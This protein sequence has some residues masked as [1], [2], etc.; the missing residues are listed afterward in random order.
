MTTEIEK[1]AAKR[2]ATLPG[3]WKTRLLQSWNEE[4]KQGGDYAA[5]ADRINAANVVLH[6]I[7]EELTG[8]RLPLDVTDAEICAVAELLA[9]RSFE[10]A[11]IYHHPEDLRAALG[12][13]AENHGIT[14]PD[15]RFAD[16]PAIA[17]LSDPMWWRRQLRRAHGRAVE[18]AAIAIGL[19]N[20]QRE[21]YASNETVNRRAAQVQRNL[22]TL[23][24]T[25]AVNELGQEYTLAE[26]AAKGT[27]NKAIRRT[28]LM[29]RIGG[30][31]RIAVDMQH[32]GLF[33]TLTAPSR[34]HKFTTVGGKVTENRKYDGTLPNEAQK[35]HVKNWAL[36][37]AALAR[38]ELRVYGFRVVEPNHDETPH[39]HLLLFFSPHW[40]GWTERAAYPRVCAIV[41]RYCLRDNAAKRERGV[42]VRQHRCDFKRMEPAQGQAGAYIAKYIAKNI[43]GYR[44]EKDLYGNDSIAASQRIEA[45][46][47][48]WGIRQFQQVGGPPV[49]VWRELRRVESVPENAPEAM[50]AAHRAA[51]KF[52]D[53]ETG[54]VKSVSWAR[55]VK[56]QGGPHCGRKYK[57]R[58]SKTNV[59]DDGLNRY[60][61]PSAP[62][63]IGI[64]MTEKESYLPA[65]M[66]HLAAV[67]ASADRWV[68]WQVDSARHRWEIRPKGG[69]RVSGALRPW[70]CVN[71][72]TQGPDL[73][74]KA[75]SENMAEVEH[76]LRLARADEDRVNA[77]W[78]EL[79]G[80]SRNLEKWSL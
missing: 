73:V 5:K 70:P 21:C 77:M 76:G 20:K 17:R 50:R 6:R 54:E 26:L 10:L 80:Q 51:N 3:R 8:Q 66:A 13:I 25:T 47:T 75:A 23:E 7:T 65:H 11:T 29:T 79:A 68:L 61:E 72:C 32:A 71:N 27:S 34:M 59:G 31:E 64:E 49:T 22:E 15:C 44:L 43:D 2:V 1:W 46:A 4:R 38:R 60:G 52:A 40:P 67:G 48:T 45:W 57:V 58:V 53:L 14:P 16:G 36:I 24:S 12:G 69:K 55:Y 35:Y 28:E 56:A 74:P 19:V 39:W 63:P 9:G 18:A 41:R 78:H 37:R 33:V 62:R 30:F 42:K